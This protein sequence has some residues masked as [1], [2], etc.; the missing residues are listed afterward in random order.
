MVSRIARL[1]WHRHDE[2]Q[3]VREMSSDYIDGELDSEST[4][5]VTSHLEKCGPCMAFVNTMRAT[6][7][8]LRAAAKHPTPESLRQRLRNAVQQSRDE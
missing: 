8:M 3:R 7:N 1:F 4:G 5:V 2:H 6:V